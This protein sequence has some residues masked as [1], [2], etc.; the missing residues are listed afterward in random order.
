MHRTPCTWCRDHAP[1]A[2]QPDVLY[3][4]LWAYLMDREE[5]GHQLQVYTAYGAERICWL[6]TLHTQ[7]FN[8][9]NITL[10][11]LESLLRRRDNMFEIIKRGNEEELRKWSIH[12]FPPLAMDVCRS[13]PVDYTWTPADRFHHMLVMMWRLKTETESF[14]IEK[15]CAVLDSRF[16]AAPRHEEVKPWP[17][18]ISPVTKVCNGRQGRGG[19]I[20][21]SISPIPGTR[22]GA[23]RALPGDSHQRA[24]PPALP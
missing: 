2:D 5:I 11:E 10:Q 14:L 13:V 17:H 4:L 18:G 6:C 24:W 16:R 21:Q 19:G 15:H 12:S 7:N 3:P 8:L 22:G 23:V 9:P 20:S 1:D